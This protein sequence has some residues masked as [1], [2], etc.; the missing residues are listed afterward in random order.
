MWPRSILTLRICELLRWLCFFW[1]LTPLLYDAWLDYLALL[2]AMA[3]ATFMLGSYCFWLT[4][5][6][7]WCSEW[8][9]ISSLL[10]SFESLCTE[11]SSFL[12]LTILRRPVTWDFC[13]RESSLLIDSF[14][15]LDRCS[16]LKLTFSLSLNLEVD[17]SFGNRSCIG[18]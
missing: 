13:W 10:S 15:M 16:R 11:N 1:D 2:A 5:F 6:S 8:A 7:V 18:P 3:A 12:E 9:D 14:L 4:V 17:F